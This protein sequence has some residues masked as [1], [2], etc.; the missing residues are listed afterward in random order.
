MDRVTSEG[1][2]WVLALRWR[3]MGWGF[4][5]SLL[6]IML[7]PPLSMTVRHD[8][9]R[10][11]A[12]KAVCTVGVAYMPVEGHLG[13]VTL[14]TGNQKTIGGGCGEDAVIGDVD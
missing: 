8:V 12:A 4:K 9:H 10:G 6:S 13:G 2:S 11:T 5:R 3:N 1:K 7:M 14:Y